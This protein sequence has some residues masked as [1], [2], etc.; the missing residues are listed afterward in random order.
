MLAE[1]FL[2]WT[3]YVNLL[4]RSPEELARREAFK[5]LSFGEVIQ[6]T[7]WLQLATW[8]LWFAW[9]GYILGCAINILGGCGQA[10]LLVYQ[11]VYG[12]YRVHLG[13]G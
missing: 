11:L 9:L 6:E 8:P 2:L 5:A 12:L 3:V 13:I 1:L 7:S 4:L 10:E